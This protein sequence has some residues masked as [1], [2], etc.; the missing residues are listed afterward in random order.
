MVSKAAHKIRTCLVASKIG[1]VIYITRDIAYFESIFL[2]M[3][4]V[5]LVHT[6]AHLRK[7][8]SWNQFFR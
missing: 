7:Q 1:G 3:L 6:G 4:A 2:R 5:A 8:R